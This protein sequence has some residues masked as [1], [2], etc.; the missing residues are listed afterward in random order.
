MRC[1]EYAIRQVLWVHAPTW[2]FPW[3]YSPVFEPHGTLGV[4]INSIAA[5]T[6]HRAQG[7][8]PHVNILETEYQIDLARKC[9]S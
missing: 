8:A 9:W 3:S 7:T 4:K 6:R 2:K 1:N 5:C